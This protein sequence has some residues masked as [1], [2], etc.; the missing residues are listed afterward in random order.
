MPKK[1][2][3]T[4]PK[5]SL[6]GFGICFG[7][8]FLVLICFLNFDASLA[9]WCLGSCVALCSFSEGGV[10]WI[11]VHFLLAPC[12]GSQF[13]IKEPVNAVAVTEVEHVIRG[14]ALGQF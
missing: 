12:P 1:F 2:Q 6:E 10:S 3:I 8:Y 7:A 9:S 11:L 14:D 13:L 5:T 4:N